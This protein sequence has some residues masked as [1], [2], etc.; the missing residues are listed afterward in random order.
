METEDQSNNDIKDDYKENNNYISDEE[1]TLITLPKFT[2]ATCSSNCSTQLVVPN[3][4][5]DYGSAS[6]ESR[7]IY[8]NL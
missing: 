2:I 1:E 3:L 5:A 8:I 4:V 7:Y 6:E